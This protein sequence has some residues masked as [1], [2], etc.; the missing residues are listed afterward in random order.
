MQSLSRKVAITL[1][2]VG[3]AA[4]SQNL[5]PY[6]DKVGGT[7]CKYLAT[8]SQIPK[9]YFSDCAKPTCHWD[10]W[11]EARLGDKNKERERYVVSYAHNGFGNQ[12]WQHTVAFMLAESFKARLYIAI[13]PD[14]LSPDGVTPPNTFTGMEAMTRL[15]PSQFLYQSLPMN[16]SIRQVCDQ[17][18]F[19]VADRPRDWRNGTYSS[20]FKSN[21]IDLITDKKPR[22]IKMLGYF[23]NLPLCSDDVKQLWT[24]RMLANY[25]IRPGP[26]DISIYLRCVPR[27]Y[28][29]NDKNYYETILNGAEFDRVWL[30]QAP[31]C[32]TRLNKD[33]SKDGLVASVIRLLTTKF[34]ATRLVS[35]SSH[36]LLLLTLEIVNVVF[37][38]LFAFFDLKNQQ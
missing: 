21:L 22:C 9:N 30:F 31:E 19:F 34:N 36:P 10:S 28:H 12:L 26:N 16:S 37:G 1:F 33:S 20:G 25:T 32:P 11:Q 14:V 24:P 8:K 7:F 5:V 4:R 2:A 27:H 29:F 38:I 3:I 13:I 18:L 35:A 6:L 15:L 23:Q 17:E